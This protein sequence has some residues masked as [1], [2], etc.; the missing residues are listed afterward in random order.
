MQKT[1]YNVLTRFV[2]KERIDPEIT[3]KLDLIAKVAG[4]AQP[5]T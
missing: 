3:A 5:V 4:L 2:P 1:D